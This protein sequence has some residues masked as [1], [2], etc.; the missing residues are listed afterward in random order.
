M[1]ERVARTLRYPGSTPRQQVE[2]LMGDYF[3]H[4]RGVARAVAWLRQMTPVPVGA[5]LV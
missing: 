3:R 5:N 2:R 4:A 1:Q